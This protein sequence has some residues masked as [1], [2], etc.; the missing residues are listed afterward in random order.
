MACIEEFTRGVV[1]FFDGAGIGA[2]VDVDIQDGEEDSDTAKFS[3]PEARV[4]RFV[5]AYD[6]PIRWAD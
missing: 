3:K 1:D 2:A 6:F 5:Y 4:F